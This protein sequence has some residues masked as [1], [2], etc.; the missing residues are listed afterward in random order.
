MIEAVSHSRTHP[1]VPYYDVESEVLGS[2]Q[3]IIDNLN[4]VNHN[5]S[6][7]N[8]YVLSLIHI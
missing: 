3:D 4:L 6:G 1:F 8:E 2:K 5:R 7:P